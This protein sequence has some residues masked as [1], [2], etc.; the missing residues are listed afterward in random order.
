MRTHRRAFTLVELLVVVGIIALL[1]GILLPALSQARR[2]AKHTKTSACLRELITGYI[3]YHTENRNALPPGYAPMSVN[4]HPVT[5]S[6]PTG[7]TF[8]YP[9]AS[10][11][12]WRLIPYMGKVWAVVHANGP[13]P[14][15]PEMGDSASAADGKAYALSVSPTFGI[16]AVYLGGHKDYNAFDGLG[17]PRPG[18]HVIFKAGE[19]SRP[20]EIVVFSETIARIGGALA[21]SVEANGGYHWVTPPYAN[22]Q[23][24]TVVNEKISVLTPSTDNGLPLSRNSKKTAVAMFDGHVESL[25][26]TELQDMR[27][28]APRA[29]GPI[30]DIQP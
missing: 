6:W 20:T 28:W 2:M 13:L 19:I 11:Y 4:G 1:I 30:Y 9:T 14:A 15:V 25:S 22:G 5:A 23:R 18:R 24:W 3:A 7:H 10:R 21:G 16:N 29:T 12:P 17:R 8:Y 26:L 27:R